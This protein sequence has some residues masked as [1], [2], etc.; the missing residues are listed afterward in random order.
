MTNGM[1][2]DDL[3]NK[4]RDA[5]EDAATNGERPNHSMDALVSALEEEL[6]GAF[7]GDML[8]KAAAMTAKE[9]VSRYELP[10]GT[11]AAYEGGF[12]T[13]SEAENLDP[14]WVNVPAPPPLVVG[15]GGT[16]EDFQARA[17]RMAKEDATKFVVEEHVVKTVR[18]V[19]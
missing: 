18:R 16:D 2:F 1:T 14:N 15:V 11:G 10:E 12:G 4:Y 8:K 3:M 6:K 7:S 5:V 17:E 19:R 13:Y 9:L